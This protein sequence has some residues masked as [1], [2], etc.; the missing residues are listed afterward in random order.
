MIYPIIDFKTVG[1]PLILIERNLAIHPD[2]GPVSDGIVFLVRVG[3]TNFMVDQR[4][5]FYY[6]ANGEA[7]KDWYHP[8]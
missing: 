3:N 7:K 6:E 2:I 8:A 4:G 1:A 5:R